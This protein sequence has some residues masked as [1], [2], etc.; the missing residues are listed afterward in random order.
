V[1]VRVAGGLPLDVTVFD[2]PKAPIP[3]ATVTLVDAFGGDAVSRRTGAD[4]AA[5]FERVVADHRYTLTA[6]APGFATTRREVS[7]LQP[8]STNRYVA[9]LG[10]APGVS[11]RGVVND[12]TGRP[13]A[14][15]RVQAEDGGPIARTGADGTYLL[16]G[17]S[18]VVEG[19]APLPC[20]LR[21]CRRSRWR[22][23]PPRS[24]WRSRS[25][26]AGAPDRAR[27]RQRGPG[28][29]DGPRAARALPRPRGGVGDASRLRTGTASA[30]GE[31]TLRDV[32]RARGGSWR[33]APGVVARL[34]TPLKIEDDVDPPFLTLVAEA[35]RWIE[36]RVVDKRDQPVAGALIE[37]PSTDASTRPRASRRSGAWGTCRRPRTRTAAFGS[38]S[39][40]CHGR[41]ASRSKASIPRR[42]SFPWIERPAPSG[43]RGAWTGGGLGRGERAPGA[44]G[45]GGG[46]RGEGP[47]CIRLPCVTAAKR[48]RSPG[49][50]RRARRRRR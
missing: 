39:S 18:V 45:G 8:Q 34:A 35:R 17:V 14:G 23:P 22:A 11:L 47:R 49:S 26:A 44:R 36:F 40:R 48:L 19:R 9:Q 41:C 43:S 30:L 6:A 12:G 50:P 16:E 28:R 42:S 2:A 10:L 13:L 4:G 21:V 27:R 29:V 1:T 24:T 7:G 3:G 25:P 15:A 5:T 38:R 46:R 20:A 32:R 31:F 37:R 33:S